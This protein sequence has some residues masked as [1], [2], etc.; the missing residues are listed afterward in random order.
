MKLGIFLVQ[1][2]F[3]FVS[4]SSNFVPNFW[5]SRT[6]EK[7]DIELFTFADRF[8]SSQCLHGAIVES[9]VGLGARFADKKDWPKFIF[10]LFLLCQA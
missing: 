9:E 3:A 6:P 10:F 5:R 7:I 2:T 1:K 4:L 8:F